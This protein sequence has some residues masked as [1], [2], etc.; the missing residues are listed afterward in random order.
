[1]LISNWHAGDARLIAF[2]CGDGRSF[3]HAG[4]KALAL[5]GSKPG[6]ER[7]A[8]APDRVVESDPR[9]DQVSARND[10]RADAVRR[11]RFHMHLLVEAGSGELGQSGGVMRVSLVGLHRL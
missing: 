3:L 4:K 7:R 6:A 11:G 10:N 8:D 5:A 9:F 1:M 2:S